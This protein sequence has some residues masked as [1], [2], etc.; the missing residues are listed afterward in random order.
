MFVKK[1]RKV[2]AIALSL[3]IAI[4]I[5]SPVIAYH[6]YPNYEGVGLGE[7]DL[8]QQTVQIERLAA[9]IDPTINVDP[10][11]QFQTMEGW[12]TTI[13]WWGNLVGTWVGVTTPESIEFG[14][15]VG[16]DGDMEVREMLVY[17]LFHPDHMNM[18]VARFQIGGGDGADG[19]YSHTQIRRP[20]TRVIGWTF[21]MLGQTYWDPNDPDGWMEATEALKNPEHPFWSRPVEHMH[22]WAQLW[23]LETATAIREEALAKRGLPN[24]MLIEVFAKSTPYYM[25]F[26]LQTNGSMRRPGTGGGGTDSNVGGPPTPACNRSWPGAL[27][28]PGPGPT[29][30]EFT[31]QWN[32]H[33]ETVTE[34]YRDQV[35][36]HNVHRG[37]NHNPRW[38][39]PHARY[40]AI[41]TQYIENF[42][43]ELGVA[44][45]AI[46]PFNE[47]TVNWGGEWNAVAER[48]DGFFPY[49]FS[50]PSAAANRLIPPLER[51]GPPFLSGMWGHQVKQEGNMMTTW[52][53]GQVIRH[54]VEEFEQWG[55]EHVLVAASG[56]TGQSTTVWT[57]N[58]LTEQARADTPFLST[59]SY[60]R[61]D[62]DGRRLR[63]MALT[64]GGDIWQTEVG[65]GGGTNQTLG[66]NPYSM[67][68]VE[69]Q[70]QANVMIRDVKIMQ[71][72]VWVNWIA[73]ENS[74]NMME[75]NTMWG[76][77]HANLASPVGIRWFGEFTCNLY[78]CDYSRFVDRYGNPANFNCEDAEYGDLIGFDRHFDM[79]DQPLLCPRFHSRFLHS[80]IWNSPPNNWQDGQGP[81]QPVGPSGDRNWSRYHVSHIGT[82]EEAREAMLDPDNLFGQ[83]K[84]HRFWI[85]TS[86]GGHAATGVGHM[87]NEANEARWNNRHLHRQQEDYEIH[88][89]KQF[90]VH[91]QI[92]QFHRQGN[93][94][95][96]I[97]H[98][99]MDSLASISPDGTELFITVRTTTSLD[100]GIDLSRFPHAGVAEMWVTMDDIRGEG[101][102][103][104]ETGRDIGFETRDQWNMRQMEDID[105]SNGVLHV[106]SP[107]AGSQVITYRITSNGAA[108]PG[109]RTGPNDANVRLFNDWITYR[110]F[111]SE[112]MFAPNTGHSP[113]HV[114]AIYQ[115]VETGRYSNM[116]RFDF[117]RPDGTHNMSNVH[118]L[119]HNIG[120]SLTDS[121]VTGAP[122]GTAWTFHNAVGGFG[123]SPHDSSARR[124]TAEGASFSFRFDTDRLIIRG[125]RTADSA[126]VAEFYAYLNGERLGRFNTEAAI[127]SPEA[128]LFDTGVVERNETLDEHGLP[129][130]NTLRIVKATAAGRIQVS[131]AFLGTGDP[132]NRID[133]IEE[134]ASIPLIAVFSDQDLN[135]ALPSTVLVSGFY[136][137]EEFVDAE[138]AVVW[139]PASLLGREWQAA[140][141]RGVATFNGMTAV[142][143][144]P[145]EII[146]KGL[147][148]FVSMGAGVPANYTVNVGGAGTCPVFPAIAAAA[149]LY[150]E[151]PDR[152]SG[153]GPQRM[154]ANPGYWGFTQ[155]NMPGGAGGYV[156]PAQAGAGG[157]WSTFVYSGNT[158]PMPGATAPVQNG[159][160]N[161][162]LPV[163]EPGRYF[164]TVGL[165]GHSWANR[166]VS[167][168]A[169]V[170][171]SE[172]DESLQPMQS[173]FVGWWSNQT[174]TIERG[175][176]LYIDVE[177]PGDIILHFRRGGQPA[178]QGAI[179]A[180]VGLNKSQVSADALAALD[181]A[182][183]R[184]ATHDSE[185]Y[186]PESWEVVTSALAAAN[187]VRQNIVAT[188][189]QVEEATA[190]LLAALHN[191]E[192]YPPPTPRETLETLV[193]EVEQMER[194]DRPAAGWTR[195]ISALTA[196]NRVLA[197]AYA[198]DAQILAA[199]RNLE[200]MLETLR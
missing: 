163:T 159:A 148:Y 5:V 125:E 144:A 39:R 187:V 199:Q 29:G 153:T 9:T 17:Q 51:F 19:F 179:V 194:G 160:F 25:T 147:V 99:G 80:D 78:G 198:T 40:M 164:I 145:V 181:E 22:D 131:A 193:A 52:N 48:T 43:L 183:A 138:A 91:Q 135:E 169:E 32:L 158:A 151:V 196:A 104:P 132:A 69:A 117:R 70:T 87:A 84:D 7:Y 97:D 170:R 126:N 102:F 94:I 14:R 105:V 188:Q 3:A 113:A 11:L 141:V 103:D 37:E 74:Y 185:N 195:L 55:L 81:D 45:K 50:V 59:H 127:T 155:T 61:S 71:T 173:I 107:R 24:D 21:D 184:V 64:R 101:R 166:T 63:D 15:S 10:S 66:W 140:T 139:N 53:Q 27:D 122:G 136:D 65:F 38:W 112:V 111:N 180:W 60:G 42:A 77:I 30:G 146:P 165:G 18:N 49:G 171:C 182:I 167:L 123:N 35:T 12:G 133:G 186:T 85:A 191:L 175:A 197:N 189:Q 2:L 161:Y 129:I 68:Q 46:N 114:Q 178:N 79:F 190:A 154:I 134:V 121:P 150:N 168:S 157:K 115:F 56:D 128:I 62:L 73:I 174:P 23:I 137:G 47:P 6:G 120:N 192:R 108:G 143:T 130:G 100:V 4:V 152:A 13:A 33:L 72:P 95:I 110:V 82:V 116:N 76:L 86:A 96:D 118:N 142:V 90:Y 41:A 109:G 67:A 176:N 20:D 162:R 149:D 36:A 83:F 58:R 89:T 92:G 172:T 57:W 28:V 44:V 16:W 54:F 124:A 119:A 98:F 31:V 177:E 200:T 93:I 156:A 26:D 8:I 106:E 88:Y 1:Y 75:E 34:E